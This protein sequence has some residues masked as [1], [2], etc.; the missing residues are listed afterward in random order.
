MRAKQSCIKPSCG[1]GIKDANE[2]CDTGKAGSKSCT[3]H[4]QAICPSL[5]PPKGI[6]I[7]YDNMRTFGSKA[8]YTCGSSGKPPRK[9]SAVR[10]CQADGHWSGKPATQCTRVYP[11]WMLTTDKCHGFRKSCNIVNFRFA[12]SKS[13]RFDRNRKYDCPAGFHWATVA[14]THKAYNGQSKDC[15][16]NH[17]YN[18]CGW[19]GYQ[20]K[21]VPRESFFLADTPRTRRIY[22]VGGTNTDQRIEGDSYSKFAGI[23]C[24][25]DK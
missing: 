20:W 2:Q 4:C 21:R 7:S 3:K 10:T 19:N 22:H 15:G 13:P 8:K 11:S 23:V 25:P 6:R 12:V 14:E 1:D 9:G 17:Y 16:G 18:R 24:A 5:L